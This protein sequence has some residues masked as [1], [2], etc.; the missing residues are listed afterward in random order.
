MPRPYPRQFGTW[1]VEGDAHRPTAVR[2]YEPRDRRAAGMA[3]HNSPSMAALSLRPI[4][5]ALEQSDSRGE[6]ATVSLSRGGTLGPRHGPGCAPTQTGVRRSRSAEGRVMVSPVE[7]GGFGPGGPSAWLVPRR[8][9]RTQPVGRAVG[10]GGCR[11]APNGAA[12]FQLGPERTAPEQEILAE[13]VLGALASK[14]AVDVPTRAAA[15]QPPSYS[16]QVQLLAKTLAAQRKTAEGSKEAEKTWNQITEVLY[17]L[18]C[19]H[20]GCPIRHLRR[21]GRT[22]SNSGVDSLK[23]FGRLTLPRRLRMIPGA[24]PSCWGQSVARH[25]AASSGG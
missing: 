18:G 17:Q 2:K 19:P 3:T 15:S 22:P 7:H 16:S 14:L 25:S 8:S 9:A 24:G 12:R 4:E 21:S 5:R 10:G 11:R 23:S 20:P 13:V 1:A 6:E